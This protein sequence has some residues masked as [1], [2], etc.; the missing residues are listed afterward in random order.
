M[1]YWISRLKLVML[2][3]SVSTGLASRRL[4]PS[5]AGRRFHSRRNG[6]IEMRCRSRTASQ[7]SLLARLRAWT[8]LDDYSSAADRA[9]RGGNGGGAS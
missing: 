6:V 5:P 7:N 8:V 2:R 9:H 4:I 1:S 3:L